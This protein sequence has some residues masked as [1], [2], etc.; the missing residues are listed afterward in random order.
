[1][2]KVIYD[3]DAEAGTEL[4]VKEGDVLTILSKDAGDGWWNAR[5][6]SG[7][8]G[9]V[10]ATYVEEIA[11]YDDPTDDQSFSS[12]S[13]EAGW[14]SWGQP[15]P[16]AT[17]SP[18]AAKSS[19]PAA[20][21]QRA[22]SSTPSIAASEPPNGTL[23]KAVGKDLNRYSTY[24]KVGVEDYI[25]GNVSKKVD[26]KL[27]HVEDQANTVEW[28][29]GVN[30]NSNVQIA[31]TSSKSKLGGMKKFI[32]YSIK[33]AENN[34]NIERRYKQFDWLDQ[35]LTEQFP[36]SLRPQLPEKQA[37]GRFEHEFIERR[38]ELLEAWLAEVCRHP[39]ISRSLL[40]EGFVTIQTEAGKKNENWKK[41]KREQEQTPYKIAGFWEAVR[42]P[43][44]SRFI[45]DSKTQIQKFLKFSKG[46]DAANNSFAKS[47]RGSLKIHQEYKKDEL[48]LFASS[49]EKLA[50]EFA[51]QTLRPNA[52][53]L[54]SAMKNA[55]E[56][57]KKS[58]EYNCE[59]A[60]QTTVPLLDQ[61]WIYS[62]ILSRVP[63]LVEVSEQS[64]QKIKNNANKV[65][66]GT[67]EHRELEAK[68]NTVNGVILSEA[69]YL[70]QIRIPDYSKLMKNYFKS[71]AEYHRKQMEMFE[72]AAEQFPDF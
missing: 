10:P 19:P 63:Q 25:I 8:E 7:Q 60:T 21:P 18:P 28:S 40:I 59:W 56:T 11:T 29:N 31:D 58:A 33:H 71:R 23:K 67:P 47:L 34:G 32:A 12:E 57:F 37:S 52:A 41:F 1:M 9:M 38:K 69:D 72:A 49:V 44:N 50:D 17:T 22:P 20:S 54:A 14:T 36:C 27:Y 53:D 30:T 13:E 42:V 35:R 26:K 51:T 45:E 16:V 2:L 66:N 65:G 3:F 6:E 48:L 5:N 43:Q 24:I 15:A 55:A 39:I 4:T 68:G 61:L 46:F 62:G 64:H 70:D